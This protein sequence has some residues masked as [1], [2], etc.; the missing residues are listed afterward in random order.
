MTI[1]NVRR[2]QLGGEPDDEDPHGMA[3][4]YQAKYPKVFYFALKKLRD[5]HQAQEVAAE[6]FARLLVTLRRGEPVVRNTE[7]YLMTTARHLV[8]DRQREA[9]RSHPRAE[10]QDS[11]MDD[12][13]FNRAENL[14]DLAIVRNL[15]ADFPP[16]MKEVADRLAADQS[17]V[18]IA[19]AMKI[20]ESTVRTHIQRI[21][22]AIEQALQDPEERR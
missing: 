5:W 2:R 7:A 12:P 21:K 14:V 9:Q 8:A 10:M 17:T 13:G 22:A 6:T 20:Q 16:R 18:Q 11:G 3:S 19:Q 4:I 1:M 15:M